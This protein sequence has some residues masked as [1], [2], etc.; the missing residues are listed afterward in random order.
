MWCEL[1]VRPT[2]GRHDIISGQSFTFLSVAV[3]LASCKVELWQ[4]SVPLCV[5]FTHPV[6]DVQSFRPHNRPDGIRDAVAGGSCCHGYLEA[7]WETQWVSAWS[8]LG[9][10]EQCG[11]CMYERS[12]QHWWSAGHWATVS[13]V[14]TGL[15]GRSQLCHNHTLIIAHPASPYRGSPAW[16]R[17]KRGQEG[18]AEGTHVLHREGQSKMSW[19]TGHTVTV[20]VRS[21]RR[22]YCYSKVW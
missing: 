10:K 1:Y 22:G 7:V 3:I 16:Y 12:A 11:C 15:I 21:W 17:S 2:A 14:G 19:S 8:T 5:N 4:N 9:V 18:R 13:Q 20:G 6:A